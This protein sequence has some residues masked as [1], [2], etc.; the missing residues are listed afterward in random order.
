MPRGGTVPR[1]TRREPAQV[2][3]DVDRAFRTLP[4]RYLGA[5][6]GFDATWHVV[7]ADVG[8]SWEV[9]ATSQ[10][11]RVHAGL[12]RRKADVVLRTDAETWLELRRGRLSGIEAFSQRRLQAR[13]S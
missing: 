11:A 10:V 7:L 9:R 8:R 6:E 12:T 2:A 13:G 4:D 1:V 3:A 5:P